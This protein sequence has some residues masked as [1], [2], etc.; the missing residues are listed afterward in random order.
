MPDVYSTEIVRPLT[1][2][3]ILRAAG[4]R[5]LRIRGA[6]TFNVSQLTN[7]ARRGDGRGGQYAERE[8]TFGRACV[9]RHSNSRR[10]P[11]VSENAMETA[12]SIR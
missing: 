4:A 8:P 12:R 9:L 1:E 7:S 2:M 6:K 11:K 3:S 5:V 10:W